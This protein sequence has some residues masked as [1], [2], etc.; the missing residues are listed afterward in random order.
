MLRPDREQE[1]QTKQQPD[2][3]E[4]AGDARRKGRVRASRQNKIWGMQGRIF[5]KVCFLGQS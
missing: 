1:Q 3:P 4:Y 5:P 2:Q